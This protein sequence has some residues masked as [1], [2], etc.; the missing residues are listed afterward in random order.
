MEISRATPAAT[1]GTAGTTTATE[2]GQRKPEDDTRLVAGSDQ[3]DDDGVQTRAAP[4]A[5]R[6]SQLDPD[7]QREIERLKQRDREV[8][9]HEQAHLTSAGPL[10]RGGASYTYQVGPDGK[11]YAIGGE[12]A[13]DTARADTPEQTLDKANRIRS[14]ALAPAQPSSQDFRVAAQASATIAEARVEIARQRSAERSQPGN[15]PG[16]GNA[17]PAPPA[18]DTPVTGG[19]ISQFTAVAEEADEIAGV[20]LNTDA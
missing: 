17:G 7:Q 12:V 14:A 15:S 13:L 1:T 3:R 10:A 16:P 5:D 2:F 9:A 8:R 4:G 20:H 19:A 6:S 11:R 18:S